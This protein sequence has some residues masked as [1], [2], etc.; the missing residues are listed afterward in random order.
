MKAS[1]LGHHSI[2][3]TLLNHPYAMVNINAVSR[4]GYTALMYASEAGHHMIVDLLLRHNADPTM[5]NSHG[6]SALSLAYKRERRGVIS[7]LTKTLTLT[8]CATL[9]MARLER[10][11]SLSSDASMGSPRK[12]S[13][14]S[15]G[16]EN[17]FTTAEDMADTL[18]D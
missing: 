7:I 3:T 2:V 15:V 16:S 8:P 11:L 18:S 1:S 17:G 12:G 4:T 14:G 6:H 13:S 10:S 9:G 5:T